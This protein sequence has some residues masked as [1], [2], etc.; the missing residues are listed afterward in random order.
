M[1]KIIVHDKEFALSIPSSQIQE[2]VKRLAADINKDMEGLTPIFL[3]ILNG[4]FMFTADLLKN[5][6]V[7]CQVSFVKYSSYMGT[8]S[9]G[10]V[11]ELIGL[12]EDVK[13][14]PVI[15]LDDI[16]DTGTTLEALVKELELLDPG[17]IR[18]AALLLKPEAFTGNIRLD[19]VGIRIPNDFIVGYG[20][21]YNG[22]GRNF[23][24]IYKIVN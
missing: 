3:G 15:I 13:G 8:S 20:L 6:S 19:Y 22:F 10:K 2:A 12:N 7:N 16:V 9:T 5:I 1:D 17:M 18:I 4:S 11:K 24:D 23:R 14:R 21:D